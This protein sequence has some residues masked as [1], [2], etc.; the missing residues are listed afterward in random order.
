MTGWGL[1]RTKM[2]II[3]YDGT[4]ETIILQTD[5]QVSQRLQ[6]YTGVLLRNRSNW[7]YRYTDIDIK[8]V[9]IRNWL[10]QLWRLINL[11]IYR[12]DPR[13][14]LVTQES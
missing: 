6:V 4:R 11:K 12:V 7:I 13:E 9:I 3:A 14:L 8:I 2:S 10:A 5:I 1:L